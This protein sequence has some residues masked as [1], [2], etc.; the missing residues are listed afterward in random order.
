MIRQHVKDIPAFPEEEPI[1]LII[2]SE[3]GVPL[4][5]H[6]FVKN[7]LFASH[8]FGGF[9]TTID[10]FIKEMFSEGLDRAS[11]GEHTLIM[12][13]ISPFFMC[14]IFKGQSDSTQQRISV[15]IDK[16]KSDKDI[17]QKFENYYQMGKKLQLRDIPALEVLI[18][19][20]FL[21][22]EEYPEMGSNHKN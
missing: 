3:G 11:F 9:L 8:L 18:N 13:S 10:H 12:S 16:I 21:S 7:K 4:F 15:F 1:I 2:V 6:S 5:S 19:S 22:N 14:Y 17:W 20:L